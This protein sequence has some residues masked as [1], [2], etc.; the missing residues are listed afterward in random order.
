ML[1]T[2]MYTHNQKHR[3]TSYFQSHNSERNQTMSAYMITDADA[4][5]LL[6]LLP[7]AQ[8]SL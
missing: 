7:G 2:T 8:P 6:L 5:T 1:A 3:G 4:N